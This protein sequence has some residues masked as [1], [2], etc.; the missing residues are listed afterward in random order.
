M[1]WFL[2]SENFLRLIFFKVAGVEFFSLLSELIVVPLN[3]NRL[4]I[5]VAVL[6][7]PLGLPVLLAVE[8]LPRHEAR[9]L[10]HLDQL[11]DPGPLSLQIGGGRLSSRGN[12]KRVTT[13]H[14]NT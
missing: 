14:A 12:I 1:T 2:S 5:P 4:L 13:Y 6:P 10:A 3:I 7:A 8:L 11:V 9:P